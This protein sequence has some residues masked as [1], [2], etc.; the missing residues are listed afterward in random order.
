M[1]LLL[2]FWFCFFDLGIS[3]L[4]PTIS[5]AN[6]EKGQVKEGIM[7]KPFFEHLWDHGKNLQSVKGNDNTD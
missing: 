7:G 5:E 1:N 6:M 3:H 2:P 4:H